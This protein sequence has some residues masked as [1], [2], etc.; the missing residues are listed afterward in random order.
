MRSV[1]VKHSWA[2]VAG[3]ASEVEETQGMGTAAGGV[4]ARMV[5]CPARP[6]PIAVR[7]DGK[8]VE[9]HKRAEQSPAGTPEVESQLGLQTE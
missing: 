8:P 2:A 5:A 4:A 6:V 1:V 3:T 7:V 9:E